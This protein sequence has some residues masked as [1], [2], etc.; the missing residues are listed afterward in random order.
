[1][2]HINNLKQYDNIK[3]KHSKSNNRNT[4][5]LSNKTYFK[6]LIAT[7]QKEIKFKPNEIKLETVLYF[8]ELHDL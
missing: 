8:N 2:T 3:N 1:M 6:S 5:N 4:H 7:V